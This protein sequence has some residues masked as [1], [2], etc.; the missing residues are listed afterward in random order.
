MAQH[1]AM[2]TPSMRES[3]ACCARRV[4]SQAG[5]SWK[6]TA[7]STKARMCGCMAS[8]SLDS[9]DFWMRGMMPS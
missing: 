2:L 5:Q 4:P 7:R 6:T 1:S 3:S 8:R 9:M